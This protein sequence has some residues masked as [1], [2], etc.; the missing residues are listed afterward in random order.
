MSLTLVKKRGKSYVIY[1]SYDKKN[2]TV[3]MD[4]LGR[5]VSIGVPIEGIYVNGE[6]VK[7]RPYIIKDDV[8]LTN[9]L[10][11]RNREFDHFNVET[12]FEDGFVHIKLWFERE[13]GVDADKKSYVYREYDGTQMMLPEYDWDD[14]GMIEAIYKKDLNDSWNKL[15]FNVQQ[16]C[17]YDNGV[18]ELRNGGVVYCNYVSWKYSKFQEKELRDWLE[19][20]RNIF[21][22]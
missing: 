9:S 1:D 11:I 20:V 10:D 8:D 21:N 19:V 17:N 4:N 6:S 18:L 2:E 5:A 16:V 7:L 22:D 15:P 13:L 12:Y 3:N 14:S